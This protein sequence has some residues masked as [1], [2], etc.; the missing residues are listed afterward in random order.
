MAMFEI[1][2]AERIA[3]LERERDNALRQLEGLREVFAEH[4]AQVEKIQRERDEWKRRAEIE[5][6]R[7]NVNWEEVVK[8]RERLALLEGDTLRGTAGYSLIRWMASQWRSWRAM[9]SSRSGH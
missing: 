1:R 3:A 8:L 9:A 2:D 7:G 4:N 6:E 5:H